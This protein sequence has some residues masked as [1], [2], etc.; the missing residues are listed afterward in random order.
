MDGGA[1]EAHDGDK[2][3]KSQE[4]TPTAERNDESAKIDKR[5]IYDCDSSGPF[6]RRLCGS[7]R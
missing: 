4:T 1:L 2:A 7:F 3:Q 6:E 5:Y